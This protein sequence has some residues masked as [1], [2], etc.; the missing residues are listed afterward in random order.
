LQC[1]QA[2]ISRHLSGECW[3]ID[4]I[5]STIETY[6]RTVTPISVSDNSVQS[7]VTN[8]NSANRYLFGS[9]NAKLQNSII[10]ILKYPGKSDNIFLWHKWKELDLWFILK[11]DV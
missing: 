9:N 11:S 6:N 2:S 10:F 1:I 5:V 8:N 7:T 3:L 4:A